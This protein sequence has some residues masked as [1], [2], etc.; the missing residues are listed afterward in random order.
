MSHHG[1]ALP[2]V[3]FYIR[4]EIR[5]GI[6]DTPRSIPT[7]LPRVDPQARLQNRLSLVNVSLTQ[8]TSKAS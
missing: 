4:N 6:S 8:V 5:H 7:A 3:C 1:M 2:L